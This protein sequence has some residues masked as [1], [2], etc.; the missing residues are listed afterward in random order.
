MREIFRRGGQT[1]EERPTR[2]GKQK[3]ANGVCFGK[4][5]VSLC[6]PATEEIE[7][8]GGERGCG[9]PSAAAFSVLTEEALGRQ[10]PESFLRIPV[11]LHRYT[12]CP[13][14][15]FPCSRV[16]NRRHGRAALPRSGRPSREQET[17]TRRSSLTRQPGT[18][19]CP[20]SDVQLV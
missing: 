2:T 10:S 9:F 5:S 6:C 13:L 15:L 17:G 16:R 4:L 3:T 20:S 8:G 7:I 19:L 1:G 14:R 12:A 11:L 18:T